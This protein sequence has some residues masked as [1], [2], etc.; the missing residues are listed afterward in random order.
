MI[1]TDGFQQIYLF[2]FYIRYT[3]EANYEIV[4]I[5]KQYSTWR[6]C[7]FWLFLSLKFNETSYF[8]GGLE[9]WLRYFSPDP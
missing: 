2:K 7:Y 8:C 4:L 5:P 6:G 9:S 1:A 3:V